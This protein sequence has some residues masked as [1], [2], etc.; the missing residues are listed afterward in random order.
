ME[1]WIGRFSCGDT[2]GG[3]DIPSRESKD[4]GLSRKKC[5]SRPSV[6]TVKKTC[7]LLFSSFFVSSFSISLFFFYLFFS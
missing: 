1:L 6:E 3:F 2:R 4:V 5:R 7:K